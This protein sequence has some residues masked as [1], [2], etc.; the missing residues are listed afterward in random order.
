[1]RSFSG[2]IDFQI[3]ESGP[4]RWAHLWF[5]V[6]AETENSLPKGAG[7]PQWLQLMICGKYLMLAR[8]SGDIRDARLWIMDPFRDVGITEVSKA[9]NESQVTGQDLSKMGTQSKALT[10]LPVA[11]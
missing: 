6:H 8:W 5:P 9:L 2:V 1:M 7:R 4:S 10:S 3:S 11:S